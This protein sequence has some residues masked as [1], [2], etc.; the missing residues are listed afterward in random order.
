[1]HD[2]NL[3]ATVERQQTATRPAIRQ[4]ATRQSSG[5]GVAASPFNTVKLELAIILVFGVVLGLLLDS[6]TPHNGLQILILA[7]YG[8]GAS[9][10]VWLRTRR[11]ESRL[12][13]KAK[14]SSSSSESSGSYHTPEDSA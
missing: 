9:V 10:W 4:S 6:I 2:D 14:L 3:T 7:F 1:M 8:V 13:K 11:V 5:F 12:Q